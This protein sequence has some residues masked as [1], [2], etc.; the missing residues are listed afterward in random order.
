MARTRAGAAFITLAL[1]LLPV[2]NVVAQEGDHTG[3]AAFNPASGRWYLHGLGEEHPAASFF[4]GIPGDVPI[5]GDWDC[6]GVETVGM[7]RPSTGFAY[8]RNSNT[9]GVADDEF[10]FGIGGDVPLAGDWDGDGCDTLGIYRPTEGRVYL[11]NSLGT[12]AA[13]TSYL[14]GV[15][16]DRPF[17]GDFDGDGRDSVGLYRDASGFVYLRNQQRTGVAETEFF[18]GVPSDQFVSGDWDLDGIDTVGVVRKSDRRAFLRNTNSIGFADLEL[19]FADAD[20]TVLAGAFPDPGPGSAVEGRIFP[21]H[22]VVAYYGNPRTAALGVL[23]ESG[24]E[25]AVDRVLAAAAPFATA[26]RPVL[27]AFEIIASVAQAAPGSDGDYSAPTPIELLRPWIDVAGENGLLVIL[28]IQPGRTTFPE[29]VR[30]YEA[31]LLEPHVGLALDPEWRVGPNEVPA[32]VVGSVSAAEVNEVSAW[33][34][35]LVVANNLPDKLFLLHQFKSSM[36]RNRSAVIA[37]PG[38]LTVLHV[39][40]FGPQA[41]KLETYGILNVEPPWWNGFKLFYDEDTNLF[42]PFEVLTEVNP[43]P[44]LISYQ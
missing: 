11:I 8:L 42:S 34:S 32:Q 3:L 22:R 37:R 16:G 20:L 4:F 7:F 10:Y 12:A 26:E 31:L 41:L 2:P 35:E 1:L 40:G 15:P 33:L 43:V 29:E 44:D 39:D 6:D 19:P 36:I 18:F 14:F 28:D 25:E 5:M 23:G 24:P 30:R 17:A 9:S 13:D 38:L 27:G 21:T